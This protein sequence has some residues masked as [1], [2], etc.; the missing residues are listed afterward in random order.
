M[1]KDLS[2][3]LE[4]I[5]AVISCGLLAF[6]IAL[7]MGL[8]A[9][10]ETKISGDVSPALAYVTLW[11]AIIWLTMVEGGQGSLVGLTPVNLD[12]YKESHKLA[13]KSTVVCY[14]GDNL[15]RYL[16]GRQFMVVLVVFTVNMSGGPNEGATLWGLPDWIFDIFLGGG[17]AM[18][19][20]TCNV[21]QLNSQVNASHCMLDY[22]N[23]YFAYFTFVVA[24][25]IEFSGLLHASYLVQYAV[26]AMAGKPIESNEEARGF[27]ANVFFW[28]RC[29]VSL[30]ILGFCFAVTFEALFSEQT[31]L[32][33]GVP[34]SA[35]I[36]VW[37]ALMCVVGMLEGMQIAFFAMAKLPESER[38]DSYWAK[39]TCGL[40]F[41]GEGVNLPGFM[42][43][44]QLCVVSC[45]FF[46]ARVTSVSL[47]ENDD[48]TTKDNIFGVSNGL[49][50]LFNFGFLGALIVTIVASISWQ[51]VAS[52]FPM[53]FLNSPFTY[54]LL[55]FCLLLESTGICNAAWVLAAI[56]K[57][58]A[59]FQRDEVYI[60]TAEERAKKNMGDD[61]SALPLG[62]GHMAKLPGFFEQVGLPPA[63][64][65]LMEND[66]SVKKFVDD[67]MDSMHSRNSAAAAEV[68]SEVP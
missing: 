68:N 1:A 64:L 53:L 41:K 13:Y 23:N 62:V 49:Q 37:V 11:G 45:M 17:L 21:G 52:A 22:I 50:E 47:G 42:I 43:G 57:K 5:N 20:L 60:G 54:F 55:S 36:V 2:Q 61:V 46:V 15:D 6:S 59:G 25:L 12:L 66:P 27:G 28:G 40:L 3:P 29:L 31:T 4:A 58:I 8:I 19:L 24:M 39:K 32:W 7:I 30:A 26:A 51:L 10:S 9:K 63:V 34:P 48:G 65:E 18:I 56:H 35:A 38:G 14:E 44:R 67:L 16:L 33:S